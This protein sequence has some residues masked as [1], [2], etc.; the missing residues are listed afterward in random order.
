ML[1]PA[2]TLLPSAWGWPA[3]RRHPPPGQLHDDA[4]AHPQAARNLHQEG[5]GAAP[6]GHLQDRP[7]APCS[8]GPTTQGK[9]TSAPDRQQGRG[10]TGRTSGHLADPP[11]HMSQ[12]PARSS[13]MLRANLIMG[14]AA[15]QGRLGGVEWGRPRGRVGGGWAAEAGLACALSGCWQRGL[16]ASPVG[17]GCVAAAGKAQLSATRAGSRCRARGTHLR[18]VLQPPLNV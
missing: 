11:V 13:A 6:P 10:Q 12:W 5:Q 9:S 8:A 3:C 4:G 14:C 16:V 7:G 18:L 17:T 15:R 2:T 1:P